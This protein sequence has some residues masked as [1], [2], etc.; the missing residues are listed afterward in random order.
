MQVRKL[1][2]WNTVSLGRAKSTGRKKVSF[3]PAQ[4]L[5]L[6]KLNG[7]DYAFYEH[8]NKIAEEISG[9]AKDS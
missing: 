9:R 5:I 8:A 6:R 4:E 1:L 2:G 7:L 3:T